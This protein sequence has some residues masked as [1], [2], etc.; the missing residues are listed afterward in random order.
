MAYTNRGAA[1]GLKRQYERAIADLRKHLLCAPAIRGFPH[2]SSA[3]AL[4]PDYIRAA[5]SGSALTIVMAARV[6]F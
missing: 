2:S 5:A 3:S 1:Y 4:R 6:S